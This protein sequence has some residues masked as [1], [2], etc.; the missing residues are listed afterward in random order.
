[1]NL[2]YK[3]TR[4]VFQRPPHNEEEYLKFRTQIDRLLQELEAFATT[5]EEIRRLTSHQ[6]DEGYM[7]ATTVNPDFKG[8]GTIRY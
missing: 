3:L 2:L 6:S 4:G 7:P 5:E 8:R 1:M